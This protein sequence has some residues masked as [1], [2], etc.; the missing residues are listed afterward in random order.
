MRTIAPWTAIAIIFAVAFTGCEY[1]IPSVPYT[2]RLDPWVGG[3]A[4]RPDADGKYHLVAGQEVKLEIRW[5]RSPSPSIPPFDD[6]TMTFGQTGVMVNIGGRWRAVRPGEGSIFI[7]V[8][9]PKLKGGLTD[10]A[11]FVVAPGPS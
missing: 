10:T 3:Q 8:S 6:V 11:Q 5:N 7:T 4:I 9:H 2:V 1:C